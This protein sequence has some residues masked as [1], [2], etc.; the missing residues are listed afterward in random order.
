MSEKIQWQPIS[1]LPLLVQM[2][3]EVHGST[4]KQTINLEKA[5][6]NPFLLSGSELL[7]TER[8]YQEQLN[9]LSLFQQ[10][11]ERW[12]AEDIQPEKEVMVMDTLERLFEMDIMTKTVLAQL[13]SF[14][15]T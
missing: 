11:C 13:K 12:L 7:R 1:M 5:K 14:V 15:G 6:G 2:V 9:S 10:Q 4:Q 3:E 8:A